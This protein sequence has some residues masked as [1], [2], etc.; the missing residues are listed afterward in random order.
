VSTTTP[1]VSL[2][3]ISD[4][5]VS[6][7][8][9]CQRTGCLVQF[10]PK[11]NKRFCGDAC[12]KQADK[13]SSSFKLRN[14]LLRKRRQKRKEEHRNRKRRDTHLDFDPRYSGHVR[15]DVPR[16]MP[17]QLPQLTAEEIAEVK[18]Q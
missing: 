5:T 17:K 11:S 13:E 9:S 16:A 8:Q 15:R 10:A 12:R 3:T 14:A 1:E 2:D 7:L 6:T 4:A 18:V